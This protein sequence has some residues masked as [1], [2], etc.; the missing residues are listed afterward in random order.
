MIN[1]QI[2]HSEEKHFVHKFI[3]KKHVISIEIVSINN[4]FILEVMHL[5]HKI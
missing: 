3:N 5:K 4:V 1:I 2:N